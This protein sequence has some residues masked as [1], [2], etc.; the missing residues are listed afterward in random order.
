MFEDLTEEQQQEVQAEIDRRVTAAVKTASKNTTDKITREFNEKYGDLIAQA[1]NP[2]PQPAQNDADEQI[3]KLQEQLDN[4]QKALAQAQLEQFVEKKLFS[5]GYG[6]EQISSLLPMFAVGSPDDAATKIDAFTS[7]QTSAI[8][9]ALQKQKEEL[10][11]GVTP[12]SSN[13]GS[14]PPKNIED[15]LSGIYKSTDD[16]H[17][18]DASAVQLLFNNAQQE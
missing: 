17:L 14:V 8:D 3:R 18:A 4:Q 7:I 13:G 15:Q 6:E 9:A 16:P 11:L 1:Q 2:Q 12:P 10:A 5:A